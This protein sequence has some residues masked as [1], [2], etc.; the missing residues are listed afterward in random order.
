MEIKIYENGTEI[1]SFDT[2]FDYELNA[3]MTELQPKMHEL[4]DNL[5]IKKFLELE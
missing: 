4:I 2:T 3:I 1:E 5:K